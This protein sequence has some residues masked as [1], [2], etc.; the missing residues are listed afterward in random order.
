MVKSIGRTYAKEIWVTMDLREG[1]LG[2]Y[3]GGAAKVGLRPSAASS[4][5]P[6]DRH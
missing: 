4:M 3:C 1:D 5:G 2:Y 6:V